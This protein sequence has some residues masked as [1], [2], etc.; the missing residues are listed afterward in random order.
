MTKGTTFHAYIP[1]RFEPGNTSVM[2]SQLLFGEEFTLMERSSN[3]L[4]ISLDFDGT[5]GFGTKKEFKENYDTFKKP[6]I[7]E[8]KDGCV[9]SSLS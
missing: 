9:K 7:I 5:E 4:S 3:W 2:I 1:I 8:L 6:M